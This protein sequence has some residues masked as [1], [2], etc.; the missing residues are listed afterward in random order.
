MEN[1]L[2]TILTNPEAR[3][4]SAQRLVA[5][6]QSTPLPAALVEPVTILLRNWLGEHPDCRGPAGTPNQSWC[7]AARQAHKNGHRCETFRRRKRV[8]EEAENGLKWIVLASGYAGEIGGKPAHN[9]AI[10]RGEAQKLTRGLKTGRMTWGQVNQAV[11]RIRSLVQTRGRKRSGVTP[12]R[13]PL[14]IPVSVD[15]RWREVVTVRALASIGRTNGLCTHEPEYA[16]KLKSGT[17]RFFALEKCDSDEF[18]GLISV[19]MRG[20]VVE[21]ARGPDNSS[22][23]A[24]REA[25]LALLAALRIGPGRSTDLLGLGL[26]GAVP[27]VDLQEPDLAIGDASVWFGSGAQDRDEVEEDQDDEG[28][29]SHTTAILVRVEDSFTLLRPIS[30]ARYVLE[31]GHDAEF[32][33][34]DLLGRLLMALNELPSGRSLRR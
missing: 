31:Q 17:V 23:L 19:R 15:L 4:A 8:T 30:D 33:G 22:L 28:E 6:Q 20:G 32:D 34:D 25:V 13:D 5:E 11:K 21:G 16:R 18:I 14:T 10:V 3:L 12:V 7:E 24:Y 9:D 27:D 1:A 29:S 2:A 26:T